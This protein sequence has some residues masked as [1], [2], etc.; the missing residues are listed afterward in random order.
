[1]TQDDIPAV[2]Q[3][4]P[5]DEPTVAN[6]DTEQPAPQP[7]MPAGERRR[8]RGTGQ[9]SGVQ[10]MF[11][12]ILAIGMV[13][14]INFSSRIASSQPLRAYYSSLETEIASL[15][16]E[17]QALIEERDF[18]QSEAYV[19]QW[20]RSEGK[21]VRPGEVLVIPRP[22]GPQAQPTAPPPPALADLE[23]TAPEPEPW[24]LWW[25]LLFDSPP[26]G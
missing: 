7:P 18:A 8:R 22:V 25:S 19:E 23:T 12:A 4:E 10:V 5:I 26:P 16:R 9:L 13:L 1:M 24:E 2:A 11:A 14:G 6:D 3:P 17:Q 15:Q 20:A 21:M